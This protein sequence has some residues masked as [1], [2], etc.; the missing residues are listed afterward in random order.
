MIGANNEKSEREIKEA[1]PFTITIK[2]IKYLGIN[3]PKKKKSYMQKSIV[4]WWKKSK[5]I[6]MERYI[7]FLNWKTQYCENDYT[8]QS[9]LQIQYNLYQ[10]INGTFHRPWTKNFTI[11]MERRKHWIA[12]AIWRKKKW[13][14]GIRLPDFILRY[15]LIKT[16]WYWHKNRNL[17]QWNRIK[18]PEINPCTYGHQIYDKGGKNIQWRKPLQ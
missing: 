15:K 10:I 6:Q 4:H 16:V 13:S 8:T 3:P 1:I 17:D 9:S 5:M 12:K 2:R 7:M 14:G 18:S 11:C